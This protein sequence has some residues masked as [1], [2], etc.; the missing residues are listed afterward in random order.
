MFSVDTQPNYRLL[1]SSVSER[2]QLLGAAGGRNQGVQLKM[3]YGEVITYKSDIPMIWVDLT[4]Q[5]SHLY[6]PH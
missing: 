6:Y 3:E 2:L 5:Y 4:A 1:S